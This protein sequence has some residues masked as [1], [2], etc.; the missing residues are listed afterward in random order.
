MNRVSIKQLD[1]TYH[2]TEGI[3]TLRTNLLFTREDRK[4]I[5]VTSSIAGEGKST[6]AMELA[7]SL[8]EVD[9]KVLLID[10]DLR[11]TVIQSR[12]QSGKVLKGLSHFLSGQVKIGEV[13]T[14]TNVKNF[15]LI[16][17]G[18]TVL[19]SAE[20]LSGALF[21]KMLN[22]LRE[23]YDYI[24][25]DSAPVGIVVDAAIIGEH[26]DAAIFVVESGKVKYKLAQKAV[27]KIEASGCPVLGTVVNKHDFKKIGE[28]YHKYYKEY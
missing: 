10:A 4:V 19:N 28:Y 24:I 17:G 6:V 27:A 5:L 2:M 15:H 23:H 20:L 7:S 18:Q 11:K 1:T 8:A 26:A 14:S 13:I 21:G 12:L 9:K 22:T 16:V 3:R 25:V